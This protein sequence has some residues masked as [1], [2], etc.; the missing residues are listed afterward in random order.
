MSNA[1][2]KWMSWLLIFLGGCVV[3]LDIWLPSWATLFFDELAMLGLL[4]AM[5]KL[6]TYRHTSTP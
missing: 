5:R 2:E 1:A 3:A 6:H 4:W